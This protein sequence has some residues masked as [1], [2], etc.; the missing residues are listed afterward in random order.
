MVHSLD[1]IGYAVDLHTA[2][3]LYMVLEWS[4]QSYEWGNSV[5]IGLFVGTGLSFVLFL[6]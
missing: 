3:T 5:V 6:I 1:L 4:G 2:T